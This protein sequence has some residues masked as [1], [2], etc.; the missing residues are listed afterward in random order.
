[1]TKS[2]ETS[3]LVYDALAELFAQAAITTSGNGT[4][5]KLGPT[6]VVKVV[7]IVSAVS[8]TSPTMDIHFEQAPDDSTYTD[9]PGGAM[10]QITAVGVY[11][12]YLKVTDYWL[13]HVVAVGGTTPS[14]TT[15]IFVTTSDK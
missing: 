5:K 13:R 14:F 12:I 1:M 9:I 11:V 6:D 10:A 7:V 3:N 4:G 8:G 2:M 15:W